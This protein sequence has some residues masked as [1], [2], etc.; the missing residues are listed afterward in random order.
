M[1]LFHSFYYGSINKSMFIRE[2]YN[3]DFLLCSGTEIAVKFN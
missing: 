1:I 2:L 3:N